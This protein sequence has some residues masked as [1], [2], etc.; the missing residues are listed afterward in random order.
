[1][2]DFQ[3][4]TSVYYLSTIIAPDKPEANAKHYS[5]ENSGGRARDLL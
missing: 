3:R 1:M 2:D 5:D 4:E